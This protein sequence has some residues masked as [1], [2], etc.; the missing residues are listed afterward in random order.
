M[1][2]FPPKTQFPH[3]II[4]TTE[5]PLRWKSL[6]HYQA[7]YLELYFCINDLLAQFRVIFHT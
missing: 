1:Y 5:K 4:V 2:I 7:Q 6:G 3:I